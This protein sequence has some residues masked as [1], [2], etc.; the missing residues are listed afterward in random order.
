[1]AWRSRDMPRVD[2]VFEMH[3][4]EFWG[5]YASVELYSAWL[6][7]PTPL[8]GSEKPPVVYVRPEDAKKYRKCKAYPLEAAIKLMG[9]EYFASSFSYALAM[10]INEGAT[11]IAIYGVDL[12]ADDEYAYQ[13]PNAEY[14]LGIARG[15]GIKIHVPWQSALLKAQ[16]VYGKETAP[17][18]DPMQAHFMKKLHDYEEKIEDLMAQ[19]HT[20]SGAK[21]EASEIVEAFKVKNRGA[22]GGMT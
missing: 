7:N 11:E 14:L 19:M 8:G 10:A 22:L 9:C 18:P 13:R 6:G 1:M 16:W 2:R 20:L 12:V 5:D 21:Q 17:R 3:A 4:E 15:K